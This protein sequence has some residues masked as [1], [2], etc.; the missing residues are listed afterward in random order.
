MDDQTR[1]YLEQVKEIL[2]EKI[3]NNGDATRAIVGVLKDVKEKQERSSEVVA[4][5]RV[6][7]DA[8]NDAM[9]KSD[10]DQ[11]GDKI[12]DAQWKEEVDKDRRKIWAHIGKLGAMNTGLGGIAGAAAAIIM[13]AL[14]A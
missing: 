4:G 9:K 5:L 3:N 12:L 14:G 11:R 6:A 10:S 8:I 7:I 2:L 1:E 13:K